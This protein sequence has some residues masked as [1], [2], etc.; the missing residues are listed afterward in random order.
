ME[1]ED[2]SLL[3]TAR[4]DALVR[5]NGRERG[6]AIAVDGGA[7]EIERLRSFFHF[8]RQLVFDSLAAAGQERIG[9]AHQHRIFAEVDLVGAW[10]GAALDLMKQTR[11]RAA[12]EERIAARTQQKRALQ[13]VD[14]PVDRPDG[15][16]RPESNGLGGCARRDA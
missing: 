14:R 16:E 9:L 6:E 7:F 3:D 13:R 5:L 11:P 10:R 4:I 1:R 12:L 8:G 2:I 15:R